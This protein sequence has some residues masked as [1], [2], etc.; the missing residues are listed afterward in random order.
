MTRNLP[1]SRNR[2]LLRIQLI[3]EDS[4]ELVSL[5]IPTLGPIMVQTKTRKYD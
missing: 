2:N 5:T 4:H 3:T 1:S